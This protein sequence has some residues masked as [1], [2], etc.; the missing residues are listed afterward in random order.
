MHYLAKMELEE[1]AEIRCMGLLE[2]SSIVVTG[3]EDGSIRLW[4]LELFE[5]IPLNC[6]AKQKHINS[7]GA[8]C[9]FI[10]NYTEFLA[11]GDYNG[12]VSIW[13]SEERKSS[14]IGGE[15]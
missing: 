1:K 2:K 8:I 14:T 12:K 4:N 3:H 10:S 9:T 13:Q 11:C 15:A 7:I 5:N 6:D